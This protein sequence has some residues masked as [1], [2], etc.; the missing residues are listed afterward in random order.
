[1]TIRA[2]SR[3]PDVSYVL[4]RIRT[5]IRS[6]RDR[7][8]WAAPMVRFVAASRA[9]TYG[10]CRVDAAPWMTATPGLTATVMFGEPWA[11]TRRSVP[12]PDGRTALRAP[13]PLPL[14][15]Q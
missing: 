2:E 9:Y 4:S 7:E 10:P 15:T 13:R 1:M 5:Q 11:W 6:V 3:C 14:P 8:A 12:P